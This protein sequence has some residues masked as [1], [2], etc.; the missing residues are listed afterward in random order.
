MK[1]QHFDWH[2]EQS[3]LGV[4]EWLRPG[5]Y[6]RVESILDDPCAAW[7]PGDQKYYVSDNR[8]FGGLTGWQPVT[9]IE[10]GLEKLHQ[11]ATSH[12]SEDGTQHC[13]RQ[14]KSQQQKQGAPENV[15]VC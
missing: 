3:R 7:R 5:E 8:L 12:L 14:Q 13:S 10:Q 4:L 6:E 11:W 1:D 15:Y 2:K 9:S